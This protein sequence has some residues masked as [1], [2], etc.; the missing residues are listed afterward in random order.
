MTNAEK[1]EEVFGDKIEPHWKE[2]TN[3]RTDYNITKEMCN[4]CSDRFNCKHWLD[5]EWE[6]PA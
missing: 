2:C 5:D 6:R 3:G 4:K 1:F